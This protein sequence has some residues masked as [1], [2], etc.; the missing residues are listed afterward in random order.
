MGA[1][2]AGFMVM[3]FGGMAI[4]TLVNAPPLSA[5][6]WMAIVAEVMVGIGAMIFHG[7]FC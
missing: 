4:L 2:I 5:K 6:W 7:V 1:K 3:W